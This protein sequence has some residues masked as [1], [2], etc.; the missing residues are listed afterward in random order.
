MN[1]RKGNDAVQV[2]WQVRIAKDSAR[3]AAEA[4]AELD[5]KDAEPILRELD[6]A[7]VHLRKAE[8][9]AMALTKR[10]LEAKRL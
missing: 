4:I 6:I 7:L 2:G 8:A 5:G 1:D 10:L 9:E 3:A